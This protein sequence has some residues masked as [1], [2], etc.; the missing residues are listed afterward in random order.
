MFDH[1]R[2]R[3]IDQLIDGLITREG[4]FIDHP[5]DR[6]GATNWGNH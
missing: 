6:G 3:T 5:A 4:G 1:D 2:H